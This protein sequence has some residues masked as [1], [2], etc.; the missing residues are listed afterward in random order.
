[1]VYFWL[2]LYIHTYMHA[3]IHR[4]INFVHLLQIKVIVSLW[5]NGYNFFALLLKTDDFQ[6]LLKWLLLVVSASEELRHLFM[7][8]EKQRCISDIDNSYE[9]ITGLTKMKLKILCIWKLNIM[10]ITYSFCWFEESVSFY[11]KSFFFIFSKEWFIWS[12]FSH[13]TKLIREIYNKS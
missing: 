7:K 8:M 12:F 10:E 6:I 1:M 5:E 9:I 3:H 11:Q 4:V 13:Y 2:R